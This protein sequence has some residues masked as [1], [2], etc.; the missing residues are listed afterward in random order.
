MLAPPS[1][2]KP[3]SMKIFTRFETGRVAAH[4][5]I[6]GGGGEHSAAVGRPAGGSGA[7]GG[8][9]WELFFPTPPPPGGG[10]HPATK[11]AVAWTSQ[12]ELSPPYQPL[13]KSP[14]WTGFHLCVMNKECLWWAARNLS[15][16]SAS[17][18]TKNMWWE[19]EFRPTYKKQTWESKTNPHS[20]C[21][22]VLWR[23][24]G[25]VFFSYIFFSTW[26]GGT[27][28]HD[29][30]SFRHFGEKNGENPSKKTIIS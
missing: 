24:I 3:L 14:P 28:S 6:G 30:R 19:S 11:K 22:R 8:N 10:Q 23:E 21:E 5:P 4:L 25:R 17:N 12:S 9:F 2:I 13:S 15:S 16:R 26:G 1:E 18:D 29:S 20:L 7:R 27:N